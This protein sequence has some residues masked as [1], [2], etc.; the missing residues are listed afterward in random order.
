[1]IEDQKTISVQCEGAHLLDIDEI[2]IFQGSLKS[3]S[4]QNYEKLKKSIL[5]LGFSA[6]FFIW[7]T[8]NT[9]G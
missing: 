7:E 8:T 9:I 6:P 3:L 4:D 1:M 5:E 2:E